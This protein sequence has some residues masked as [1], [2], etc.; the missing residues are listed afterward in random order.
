MPG[1][2][3]LCQD[4]PFF[5]IFQN[6]AAPIRDII[7]SHDL[8]LAGADE[9]DAYMLDLSRCTARQ[10]EQIVITCIQASIVRGDSSPH[11]SDRTRAA[12]IAQIQE[13]GLPIRVSQT[14]AV[15]TDKDFLRS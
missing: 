14:I 5:P 10:F 12:V 11:D 6:G 15:S 4:S 13:R 2:A 8:Q 9:T 1:F 3:H 7:P